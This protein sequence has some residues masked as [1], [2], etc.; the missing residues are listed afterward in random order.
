V[1]A[2]YRQRKAVG[3][4]GERLAAQAIEQAGLRVLDRNWRCAIG[5][6]DIVAGWRDL[7]VVCE[8]KT[9]R[10]DRFGSPIEAITTAK[11]ARLYRLGA[12]WAVEHDYSY[13]R[14]RVDVVSVLLSGRGRRRVEHIAGVC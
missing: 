2:T 1:A 10:G 11:A 12:A 4:Y 6:I 3:E 5:E 13:G 9:R 8:V 7:L 14:M